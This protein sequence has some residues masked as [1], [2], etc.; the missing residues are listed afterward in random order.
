MEIKNLEPK[1]SRLLAEKEGLPI[2]SRL[3]ASAWRPRVAPHA[4]TPEGRNI[5][6]VPVNTLVPHIGFESLPLVF[7]VIT[8]EHQVPLMLFVMAEKEGFE[9]SNGF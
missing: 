8:K 4:R 5:I 9:P 6:D 3:C 2:A 7:S 1:G